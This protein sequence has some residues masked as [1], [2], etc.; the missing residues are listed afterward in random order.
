M[1]R[2]RNLW[3]VKAPIG[4]AL[5]GFGFSLASEAGH[6]KRDGAE[7]AEW[8]KQGT[9]GLAILNMGVGLYAESERHRTLWQLE[10]EGR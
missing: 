7:T 6:K 2:N 3:L 9:L 10:R 4:V 1:K 5:I 8:V